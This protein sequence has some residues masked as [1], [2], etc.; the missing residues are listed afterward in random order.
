ML[1]SVYML[2]RVSVFNIHET[3]VVKENITHVSGILIDRVA[4]ISPHPKIN[5]NP[6]PPMIFLFS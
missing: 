2:V 6:P 1:Y 3:P 5:G 4:G